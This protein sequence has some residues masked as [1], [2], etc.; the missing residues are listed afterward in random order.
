MVVNLEIDISLYIGALVI[1]YTSVVSS[2][3][4]NRNFLIVVNML[5]PIK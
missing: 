3:R 2:L 4:H 1:K 5:Q